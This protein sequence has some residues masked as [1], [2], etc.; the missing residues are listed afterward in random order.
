MWSTPMLHGLS[1]PE[2]GEL[3]PDVAR[4]P[5]FRSYRNLPSAVNSPHT[6]RLSVQPN[7]PSPVM[8]SAC[9]ASDYS[10]FT[11]QRS[12][13]V[14][15]TR[16]HHFGSVINLGEPSPV[17]SSEVSAVLP[18]AG[19]SFSRLDQPQLGWARSPYLRRERS[20]ASR[21]IRNNINRYS[22]DAMD[23]LL[24]SLSELNCHVPVHSPTIALAS[25]PF[26]HSNLNTNC[27]TCTS[28]TEPVT[29]RSST[30]NNTGSSLSTGAVNSWAQTHSQQGDSPNCSSLL[31]YSASNDSQS[32][33]SAQE[34]MS[35]NRLPGLIYMHDDSNSACNT[36]DSTQEVIAHRTS[37]LRPSHRQLTYRRSAFRQDSNDG[38]SSHIIPTSPIISMSLARPI[39]RP[40]HVRHPGVVVE[41]R[42]QL[43]TDA[44]SSNTSVSGASSVEDLPTGLPMTSCQGEQH[45]QRSIVVTV[46]E[47][48]NLSISRTQHSVTT[49]MNKSEEETLIDGDWR[50]NCSGTRELWRRLLLTERFAD[51]YFYVGGTDILSSG[52]SSQITSPDPGAPGGPTSMK[53]YVPSQNRPPLDAFGRNGQSTSPARTV[54]HTLGSSE[55][56]GSNAVCTPGSLDAEVTDS[57]SDAD[58][59]VRVIIG[60]SKEVN[61]NRSSACVSNL[62][63]VCP[64][65]QSCHSLTEDLSALGAVHN[66]N[67]N[68]LSQ[69]QSHASTHSHTSRSESSIYGRSHSVSIQSD[70]EETDTMKGTVKQMMKTIHVQTRCTRLAAHR[71]VLSI[72]SPVFEA[73]FYGPMASI[74]S[75]PTQ[76]ISEYH[77]PDIHPKA[78]Q[79]LLLYI[80]TDELQ[81]GEDLDI[82]FY[83]LYTSKKYMLPQLGRRC[84]EHL[85]EHITAANVCTMLD[86]SIF[87]EED[88]L[89]HRC[90]HVIDVLA[91]H[92]LT[93]P[94][95]V[96][97]D[98]ARF[99]ALLKRDTLNCKEAEVFAAVKRWAE[100]ECNRRGISVSLAN[101]A[102]VAAE[103]LHLVRFPT[104]A[105]NEF[106]ENVAYS[107]FLSLEM[108]RDLFVHITQ[109]P[110]VSPVRRS[111][112]NH[113]ITAVSEADRESGLDTL[114]RANSEDLPKLDGVC[115]RATDVFSFIPR[116]G[117]KLW[118][119]SRFS[120]TGKH[121]VSSSLS[122]GH[123][124]ALSFRVSNTIFLAGIS[125]YGSTQVGERLSV[126]VELMTC[127]PKPPTQSGFAS[128]A[129]QFHGSS[130]QPDILPRSVFP[131]SSGFLEFV[132][133]GSRIDR[134]QGPRREQTHAAE[135]IVITASS[136]QTRVLVN[137]EAASEGRPSKTNGSR[138]ISVAKSQIICDGTSRL[139]EIFF[140]CP[141]KVLRGE[142]YI[143]NVHT[144][145]AS[146]PV[147][148]PSTAT[149][150]NAVTVYIGFFGRPEICVPCNSDDSSVVG[151][152]PEIA[153]K[154]TKANGK[155]VESRKVQSDIHSPYHSGSTLNCPTRETKNAVIFQFWEAADCLEHGEVNRGFLPEL[156]FYTCM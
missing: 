59:E 113:Q 2:Q 65:V 64:G 21:H 39:D 110:N 106:A 156:L 94:G 20:A 52:I 108:V 9:L 78:F 148:H 5:L 100:A 36:R 51:V 54:S 62:S 49:P 142:R 124:H 26:S 18:G 14:R 50:M 11:F 35:L 87:F 84:V 34:R 153:C 120:R 151:S 76:P 134:Q 22:V 123:Q 70:V 128:V 42:V 155:R 132:R 97:M 55:S 105:L 27:G 150:M 119:C 130:E 83:V 63:L 28:A 129:T 7:L 101:Q 72:A 57:T 126:R 86:R 75:Q 33:N 53:H 80:Y 60:R 44:Q 90:W 112:S 139:Y 103:F 118:R 98:A 58:E 45:P 8:R 145:H 96:K 68:T 40:I 116:C 107:G 137:N 79:I 73:M 41:R 4:M 38:L 117:P 149:S 6:T 82:V 71:L 121:S 144:Y 143:L 66:S 1:V 48:A 135:G 13:S 31:R 127:V 15:N 67:S 133:H 69:S 46:K 111:R 23:L 32:T 146:R 37:R 99:K 16:S 74:G 85:K 154:G 147:L 93:S 25:S 88:D 47:D 91:P 138:I 104:M 95:L 10:P 61:P 136:G 29:T 131:R 77:I 92:V 125:V 152:M 89:T 17:P 56:I 81:L 19:D 3:Y 122:N 30:A 115:E 24:P 109:Q 43:G 141:A 140:G 114:S 102:R 12:S